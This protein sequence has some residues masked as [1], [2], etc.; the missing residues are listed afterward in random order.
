MLNNFT[1][2]HDIGTIMNFNRPPILIVNKLP[3]LSDIMNS[4]TTLPDKKVFNAKIVQ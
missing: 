2:Q 4:E 3:K 1:T